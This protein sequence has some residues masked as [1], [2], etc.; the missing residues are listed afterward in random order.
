MSQRS[1]TQWLGRVY[2]EISLAQIKLSDVTGGLERIL[3]KPPGEKN[4]SAVLRKQ[5]GDQ[6]RRVLIQNNLWFEMSTLIHRKTKACGLHV[7]FASGRERRVSSAS[8]PPKHHVAGL[9]RQ[10]EQQFCHPEQAILNHR[11][12]TNCSTQP[13]C[14]SWCIL[15]GTLIQGLF[16]KVPT[17]ISSVGGKRSKRLAQW[18]D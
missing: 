15:S 9:G 18:T 11:P 3:S 4:L 5:C 14:P 16:R 13:E 7:P 10:P 1:R 17:K 2:M 12:K 8:G 6:D